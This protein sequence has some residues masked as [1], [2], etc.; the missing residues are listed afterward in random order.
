MSYRKHYSPLVL[1]HL[2]CIPEQFPDTSL[3]C[4]VDAGHSAL[5][6][7][8][9]RTII[10]SIYKSENPVDLCSALGINLS[11]HASPDVVNFVRN[12]LLQPIPA[13]SGAP[14]DDS[15]FDILIPNDCYTRSRIAPYL[16]HIENF[17][18]SFNK[19]TSTDV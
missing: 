12:F 19:D 3:K 18:N 15:A 2:N 11:E 17:I 6:Y 16:D 4:N 9:F 8:K 1:D 13:I 14:D 7:G 5:F 10:Q